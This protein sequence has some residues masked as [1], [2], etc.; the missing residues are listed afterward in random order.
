MSWHNANVLDKEPFE[1]GLNRA[2]ISS[3][4]SQ[5]KWRL[6]EKREIYLTKYYKGIS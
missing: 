5:L 4:F 2:R 6:I 1:N 3:D